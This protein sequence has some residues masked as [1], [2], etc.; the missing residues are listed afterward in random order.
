[1][2]DPRPDRCVVVRQPRDTKEQIVGLRLSDLRR[3]LG[4][5]F[6]PTATSA[7]R[8]GT[9]P[10]GE[11]VHPEGEACESTLGISRGP[12]HDEEMPDTLRHEARV[13]KQILDPGPSFDARR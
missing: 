6:I 1:M 5:P 7:W 2:A 13:S 10:Q 9:P 11:G 3:M 12:I 8:S 4:S